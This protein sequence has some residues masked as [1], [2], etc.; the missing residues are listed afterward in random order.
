MKIISIPSTVERHEGFTVVAYDCYG[1]ASKPLEISPEEI[2]FD[3]ERPVIGDVLYNGES[4]D[5]AEWQQENVTVSFNVTDLS[6]DEKIKGTWLSGKAEMKVQVVGNTDNK[7]RECTSKFDEK[8]GYTF[9]FTSDT[10]QTY[11]IV[12]TDKAGNPLEIKTTGAHQ[13]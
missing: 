8:T 10:Y 3:N 6:G 1:H 11:K 5:D 7:T 12:A 13:D 2:R 4:Y 9:S